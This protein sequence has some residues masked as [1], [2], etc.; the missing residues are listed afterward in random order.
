MFYKEKRHVDMTR[1]QEREP[2]TNLMHNRCYLCSWTW[3]SSEGLK[4]CSSRLCFPASVSA[5]GWPTAVPDL[6]WLTA[7]LA[8]LENLEQQQP[9]AAP[10][11][12]TVCTVE[13][14]WC[15]G[16][17]SVDL[18]LLAMPGAIDEVPLPAWLAAC[19]ACLAA[20]SQPQTTMTHNDCR[21]LCGQR[22]SCALRNT[23][24]V[25]SCHPP[26]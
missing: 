24:S 26:L 8:A 23:L 25:V 14:Y 9:V 11:E 7:A 10:K 5:A 20:C 22:H 1:M 2:A 15:G 21:L 3:T 6:R 13:H 18:L 4:I 12:R 19:A 17:L 16:P